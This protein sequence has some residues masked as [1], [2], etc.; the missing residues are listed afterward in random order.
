[1]LGEVLVE[2]GYITENQVAE[3][4]SEQLGIGAAQLASLQDRLL[5]RPRA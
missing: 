5:V 2:L 1:M 4:L 3:A